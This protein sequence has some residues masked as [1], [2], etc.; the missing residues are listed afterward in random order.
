M[1]KIHT[2]EVHLMELAD[3]DLAKVAGG[4]GPSHAGGTFSPDT[5]TL[6]RLFSREH[7]FGSLDYGFGFEMPIE[8]S[9]ES[10]GY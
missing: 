2:K 8:F 10:N 3:S 5:L 9:I 1:S 6:N 4:F 7:R